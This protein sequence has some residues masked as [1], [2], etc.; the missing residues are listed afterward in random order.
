MSWVLTLRNRTR[1]ALSLYF[2]HSHYAY[3]VLWGLDVGYSWERQPA[4]NAT[5]R[6]TLAPA[7]TYV[8]R[9]IPDALPANLPAGRYHLMAYLNTGDLRVETR[10]SLIV[11]GR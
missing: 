1:Q 9:L 4:Q 7:E 10:R 8:C 6:M 2:R 11:A 3:V 5:W